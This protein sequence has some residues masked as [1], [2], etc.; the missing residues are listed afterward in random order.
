MDARSTEPGALWT[1]PKSPTQVAAL[2]AEAQEQL[3]V[4][5][6]ELAELDRLERDAAELREALRPWDDPEAKRE[7]WRREEALP[8]REQDVLARV[9]NVVSLL[10][11]ALELDPE[12]SPARARLA[13]LYWLLYSRAEER[14]E[15]ASQ[16]RFLALLALHDD[17]RYADLIEGSSTLQV[18]TDP[19]GARVT[20]RSPT[21][22]ARDL[23]TSPVDPVDLAPGS[24]W[25]TFELEG[26][27]PTVRPIQVQ[28][29]VDIQLQVRLFSAREVGPD[30]RYVPAGRFRMGGDAE[31]PGAGPAREPF[32]D[33][34]AIARFPVTVGEYML[35]IDDLSA[36]DP[37]R[38]LRFS[39]LPAGEPYDPRLPVSGVPREAALAYCRWLSARTG[40]EQRLPSELEWEKAARGLD[41]RPYPWGERFDPS[42]CQMRRSQPGAPRRRRVG[43]VPTD[44][45]VF[46]V[47]DMAGGVAEWT[48]SSYGQDPGLWVVRGG[49]FDTGA[50]SCRCAARIP[51]DGQAQP[52]IGFRLVRPLAPG[53]GD[54]VTPATIPALPFEPH[55]A[56]DP[57][58]A[59]SIPVKRAL[60][61]TLTMSRRLAAGDGGVLLPELLAETVRLTRAERGLLLRDGEVLEARTS[62]GEPVPGSDSGFDGEVARAAVRQRRAIH[63]AHPHPVLALPL[64]DL[65]TCLLLERRFHRSLPFDDDGLLVAGA[66]A[67]A[68]AL[69]LRLS[70]R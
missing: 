56:P 67:D 18:E 10:G 15:P 21:G 20:L 23:G 58:T 46:G 65:S 61:Q 55:E 12:R 13:D 11:R 43:S 16:D 29:G 5:E 6:R 68:L 47:R 34:F 1:S 25:L 24:Y 14:G 33:N 8:L 41:S 7:L 69:A 51:G 35:F 49:G 3:K 22:P 36:S 2:L 31:A 38:A 39:P 57:V 64:P 45:S 70:T 27:A 52:G 37:R 50:E 28:R 32:V 9:D 60:E 19:P 59:P 40:R 63:L 17:G 53:G 4:L 26:Y 62:S 42:L 30:Y 48:G 44:V 54:R 66:A